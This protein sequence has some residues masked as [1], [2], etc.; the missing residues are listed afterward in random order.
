MTH[1]VTNYNDY[2]NE[3]ARY[4]VE[5]LWKDRYF[6]NKLLIAL[7]TEGYCCLDFYEIL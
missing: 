4:E 3:C 5:N 1:C 2:F 7:N 6:G